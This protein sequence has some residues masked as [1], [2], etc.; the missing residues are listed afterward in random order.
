MAIYFLGMKTFGRARG[1]RGSRAT[2]G[3]A[4]R[5]GER[6]RD[7][8]TGAVYDYRRRRDVLHKEIVLPAGVAAGGAAPDWARD[9]SALW[10]A[11]ESA[12]RARNARV[13]REF[14]V[15][16]PHELAPE[17]RTALARRFA[18]EIASRYGSAVDLVLH[19]PRGDPRN[20]HAHLLTTTREATAQGLGAK[21]TLELSGTERYRRGL[22][23]WAEER[24]SI[25]ERWATLANEAL[26]EARLEPRITA[27][28]RAQARA[29]ALSHASE[30]RLPLAAYHMEQRGAYSFVAERIRERARAE[31]VR[32]TFERQSPARERLREPNRLQAARDES[33][34]GASISV[35]SDRAGQ[36]ALRWA[37]DRRIGRWR[38]AGTTQEKEGEALRQWLASREA[39]LREARDSAREAPERDRAKARSR[40]YDLGL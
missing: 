17:Q 4:Y 5:A 13:A 34:R 20:F 7:E 6:I 1:T 32:P 22:A 30:P 26:R 9:R 21:T 36:A 16:L 29:R 23:R 33:T 24:A 3:A 37:V 15:G 35:A 38:A 14:T 40:D 25:R 28:D 39:R 11:A 27:L 31:L 19:A 10:N 8:R 12:E 18:Q 2:S